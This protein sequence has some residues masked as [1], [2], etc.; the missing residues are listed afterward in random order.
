MSPGE[1]DLADAPLSLLDLTINKMLCT[2]WALERRIWLLI[3]LLQSIGEGRCIMFTK[4]K[5]IIGPMNVDLIFGF[6]HVHLLL[7]WLIPEVH[8]HLLIVA[9]CITLN[10]A[11]DLHIVFAHSSLLWLHQF[12]QL[13][14]S[15]D[16]VPVL[17]DS[18]L[19]KIF[20]KRCLPYIGLL[21]MFR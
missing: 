13:L 4:D 2:P 17:I 8:C 19:L 18:C 6:I 21:L 5:T 16:N 9:L 7:L 1:L 3:L 11:G 20:L 15:G 14:G 10:I 12:H